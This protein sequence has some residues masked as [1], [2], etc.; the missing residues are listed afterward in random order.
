VLSAQQEGRTK[1]LTE[2]FSRVSDSFETPYG[3][4]GTLLTRHFTAEAQ[5]L[6]L[7]G[8]FFGGCAAIN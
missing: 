2:P 3:I 8:I 1:A 5:R 6:I 4:M 7:I